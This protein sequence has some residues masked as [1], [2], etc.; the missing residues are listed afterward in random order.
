VSADPLLV[1]SRGSALW[2]TINRPERRNALSTEVLDGLVDEI[3][4]VDADVVRSVVVTGAGDIAFCAGADLAATSPDATGLEQHEARGTLRVLFSAMQDC[5]VPVIARVRGLCLAGGVGVAL[6]ADLVVASDDARF[7]LPEVNIGLWPYM[8]GALVARHVSPKRALDW[9]LTGR[10]IDA[11]TAYDWGLVSRVVPVD[12]LD[13]EV[14]AVCEG[15]AALSPLVL[16]LG[17]AAWYDTAD[18]PLWDAMRHLHTQL[19]LTAQTRDAVEGVTAF[20]QKRDPDW[21]GR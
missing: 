21:T 1:E 18:Q 6:G 19:S 2:L 13:A 15:L 9:I 16:R 20:L 12:S 5:P 4:G 11:E 10:R 7:G 8:V 3:V 14:D 17:K